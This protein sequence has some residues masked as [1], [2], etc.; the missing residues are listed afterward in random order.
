MGLNREGAYL[1]VWFRGEGLIREGD[2]IEKG[3]NRAFTVISFWECVQSCVILKVTNTREAWPEY[4][5]ENVMGNNRS[6]RQQA[7]T[8]SLP[9]FRHLEG[10]SLRQ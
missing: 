7:F 10:Y 8:N 9:H 1:K 2:L 5:N 4:N 6:R 3:L